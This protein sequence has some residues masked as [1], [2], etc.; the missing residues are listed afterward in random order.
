MVRIRVIVLGYIPEDF[1][2]KKL[3]EW[4]SEIFQIYG[5]IESYQLPS[6]SDGDWWSYSDASLIGRFPKST[7]EDFTIAICSVPLEDNWYSRRVANN[8]IVITL[9]EI[10]DVLRRGSIP[11]ENVIFKLMYSYALVYKAVGSIPSLDRV[12]EFTHTD[13]RKCI[14]DFNGNKEEVAHSCVRPQLCPE[15]QSRLITKKVSEEDV[16]TAGV[17]L[18]RIRRSVGYAIKH[19]FS[20][21]PLKAIGFSAVS[22]LLLGVV[23]SLI[24]T[25]IFR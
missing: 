6:R 1:D 7:D 3:K 9:F 14:F 24:A 10:S 23:S 8:K 21:N 17:E 19:Y 22:T 20:C 15:C 25:W 16:R 18:H 11:L 2:V 12:Y 4:K 13:V 5:K